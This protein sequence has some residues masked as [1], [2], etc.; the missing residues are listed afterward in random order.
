MTPNEITTLIAS[1]LGKELDIRFKM[2]LYERVKYWRSTLIKQ[3]LDRAPQDAKFFRQTIYMSMEKVNTL[4]CTPGLECFAA[5]SKYEIPTVN[6][7]V[8]GGYFHYLGAV[9]GKSPFGY[10]DVGTLMYLMSGKYSKLLNYHVIENR[11]ALV[12]KL[13]SLPMLR[14]DG[15]FNNPEEAMPFSTCSPDNSPEK[16]CDW[17]DIDIPMNGDIQQRIVQSILSVDYG[18]PVVTDDHQTQVNGTNPTE[19]PR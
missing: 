3:S 11:K 14:I 1:N 8:D 15:I 6:R 7:I 17:W 16:E 13:P 2:Q 10:A 5:R 4:E 19:Q 18:R 12:Y 9:D